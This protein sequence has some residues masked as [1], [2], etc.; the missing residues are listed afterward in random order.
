MRQR[1]VFVRLRVINYIF[2][3]KLQLA[4]STENVVRTIII[5]VREV[6]G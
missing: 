1:E 6:L 3:L 2:Y 5:K 4:W